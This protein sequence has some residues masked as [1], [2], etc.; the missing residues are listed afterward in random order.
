MQQ[1]QHQALAMVFE[2]RIVAVAF[3]AHEGV[4]SVDFKP[5]VVCSDLV[6]ARFDLHAAFER[7]VRV[8]ASEDHQQLALNVLGPLE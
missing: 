2:F 7:D 6:E 3:V 1:G 4:C 8:L 5:L